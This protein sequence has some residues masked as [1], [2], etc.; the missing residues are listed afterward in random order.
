MTDRVFLGYTTSDA[1]WARVFGTDT[2]CTRE[3]AMR[4]GVLLLG[5]LILGVGCGKEGQCDALTK[6]V[7]GFHLEDRFER[8]AS[9]PPG[10]V[11]TPTEQMAKVE[12]L[13]VKYREAADQLENDIPSL[14]SLE[15][16]DQK[17]IDIR[18]G[19]EGLLQKVTS[20]ART[21]ADLTA[22]KEREPED[23]VKALDALEDVH[24][25]VGQQA[26]VLSAIRSECK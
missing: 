26:A 16:K 21:F 14:A 17:L 1:P 4:L 7:R 22:R 19:F 5:M 3:V 15:L 12:Q 9:P 8:P 6:S 20:R 25:N 10:L 2:G 11:E 23:L 24:L 13:A 18:I